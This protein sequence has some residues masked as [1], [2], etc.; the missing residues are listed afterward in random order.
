MVHLVQF[1][2]GIFVLILLFAEYRKLSILKIISKPTAAFGFVL[3]AILYG[4]DSVYDKWI[5][6]GLI[7]SFL[8]D[9]FLL[10]LNKRIFLIG[11]VSFL[12]AHIFYAVAFFP[13]AE[14][15]RQW[16]IFSLLPILLSFLFYIKIQKFLFGF[17]MP[18]LI[19]LIA[20]NTMLSIGLSCLLAQSGMNGWT[21]YHTAF[22]GALLFYLSDLAVARE[23]FVEKSFLNKSWGL[24]F[25]FLGQFLIASTIVNL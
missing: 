24:P 13:F 2:S 18:V 3:V 6:G 25:Y 14:F 16:M 22:L 7:L 19:Y 9:C 15:T 23:R 4:I 5:F 20:I 1:L 12:I 11:L 17:K 21:F 10:S 8:G